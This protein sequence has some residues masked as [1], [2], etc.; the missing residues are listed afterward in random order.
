MKLLPL[1]YFGSIEYYSAIVNNDCAFSIDELFPKQTLRNRTVIVTSQGAKNLSIP[2][3]RPFGAKTKMSEVKI[4][5]VEDWQKTHWKS[6]ESAYRSSPFFEFFEEDLKAFYQVKFE[7]LSELNLASHQL[8]ASWLK[9]KLVSMNTNEGL[10]DIDKRLADKNASTKENFKSYWQVFIDTVPF[11]PNASI[12][13]LVFCE[14]LTS[15]KFL[16]T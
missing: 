16:T 5:Y 8:I 12:L 4:S 6:I 11:V 10:G 15:L 14:G 9:L 1:T 13:D 2:V 7:Y 3:I